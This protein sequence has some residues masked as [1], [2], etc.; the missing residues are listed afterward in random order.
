MTKEPIERIEY[1]ADPDRCQAVT[2]NGQCQCKHTTDSIYCEIHCGNYDRQKVENKNIRNYY[3]AKWRAK[4]NGYTDSN[5]VKSLRDEIGILRMML[6]A[7]LEQCTSE[8]DIVLRS[9]AMS[10]LVTKIEKVVSSTDKLEKS[11][12]LMLDKQSILQFATVII[13][14]LTEKVENKELLENIADA[15]LMEVGKIGMKAPDINETQ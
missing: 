6:D 12:G 11:L 3:A 15:I 10:D 14:I 13:G 7:H 2:A 4:L 8:A 9:G 1:P 5:D